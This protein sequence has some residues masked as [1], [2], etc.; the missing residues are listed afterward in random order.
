MSEQPP[1]TGRDDIDA[2]CRDVADLANVPTSEHVDR[3][4]R[5]HEIVSGAL[6]NV[7]LVALPTLGGPLAPTLPPPGRR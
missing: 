1:I 5:A 2:A 7:P 3:L 6:S 4:T